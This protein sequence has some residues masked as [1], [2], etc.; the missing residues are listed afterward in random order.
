[1]THVWFGVCL[2]DRNPYLFRLPSGSKTESD[3]SNNESD[4]NITST[5][6]VSNVRRNFLYCS[7]GGVKG[8]DH[9]GAIVTCHDSTTCPRPPRSPNSAVRGPA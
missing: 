7:Y 6:L 1:M 5:P 9:D 3:V 8:I 2:R 4:V